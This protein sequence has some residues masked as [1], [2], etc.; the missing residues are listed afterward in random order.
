MAFPLLFVVL[1]LSLGILFA[2]LTSLPLSMLTAAMCMC[3]TGTWISFARQKDLKLTAAGLL[4]SCF[5]LG[6]SL[7]TLSDSRYETNALAI[8]KTRDYI[9]FQGRLYKTPASGLERS[10]LFLKVENIFREGR[11]ENIKGR[12]RIS[13]LPSFQLKNLPELSPG[14]RIR[15]SAQITPRGG[16]SNFEGDRANFSYRATGIHATAFTKSALLINKLKSGSPFL[17]MR[18][19][20]RLRKQ[21]QKKIETHFWSSS[22]NQL[23][24]QGAVMEALLLGQR[25]RLDPKILRSLQNSGLYHLLAISGAHVA[26]ICLFLFQFLKVLRIPKRAAYIYLMAFLV[27]YTFL[28]EGRPS[29]IRATLMTVMYLLGKL[30]WKNNHHL[31]SIS[32]SA[33]ILL[34][35]NPFSLFTLGFQLTFVATLSILLFFPRVAQKLPRFP[36]RLGEVFAV[37]LSAQAGVLPLIAL[38]FNRIVLSS[39]ILNFAALPLLFVIM[40]GGFFFLPLSFLSTVLSR[41]W[42]QGMAF[43]IDLL[44]AVAGLASGPISF[45][46]YRIPTPHLWTCLGY[47]LSGLLLLAPPRYKRTKAYVTCSFLIFA[48]VLITYP[49]PCSSKYLRVTFIDVGQ[50]DSALVEFPGR[51]KML[52][53]G[54]GSNY[55]SFDVGENIVSP[56]LWRKGIKKIDYLVST[57]PHPDHMAGLAAVLENFKIKEFWEALSYPEDP[58]YAQVMETLPQDIYK[59]KLL[60]GDVL[61]L[62]GINIEA[63]H[64]HSWSASDSAHSNNLSLVLRISDHHGTAFLFTGDI[65]AAAEQEILSQSLRPHAAVLKAPHHGSNSSSSHE[66]LQAVSPQFLVISVGEYNRYGFPHPQALARYASIGAKVYRTDHHGAVEITSG[67][68]GCT[69]RTSRK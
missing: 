21:L 45:L 44:L 25:G 53:D 2:S 3:L 31:N 50:G 19:M 30:L 68:Q 8:L 7:I 58:Y 40:A 9:D 63:L 29:V 59:R 60:Q 67:P 52:I 47:F 43:C 20:A 38:N 18:L 16:T 49:F 69:I 1:C 24:P 55:G 39:L 46:S 27:F 5:L 54:G 34:V 32:L 42:S 17:P 41:L 13:L 37:T 10:F 6:G 61:N 66:F 23:S 56:F 26:I 51:K 4:L 62:D 36:F 15:V 48:G 64:P 12:L 33:L 28:V 11:Q 14:D 65:E 57:H 35:L 22:Q